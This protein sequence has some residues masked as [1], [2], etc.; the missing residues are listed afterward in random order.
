MDPGGK[1]A[2]KTKAKLFKLSEVTGRTIAYA[3]VQVRTT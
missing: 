3:C 2:N 1:G